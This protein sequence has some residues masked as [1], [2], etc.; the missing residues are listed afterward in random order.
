MLIYKKV[1]VRVGRGDLGS[2]ESLGS[3]KG[4]AT[5]HLCRS[6]VKIRTRLSVPSL[7]EPALP[8]E[9]LALRRGMVP[10]ADGGLAAGEGLRCLY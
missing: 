9:A 10:P 3:E 8:I 1:V 7:N 4:A 2:R 6:L 5:A